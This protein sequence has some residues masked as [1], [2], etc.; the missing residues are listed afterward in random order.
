MTTTGSGWVFDWYEEGYKDLM[1][2]S[3]VS[4]IFQEARLLGR[5]KMAELARE[6]DA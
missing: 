3:E 2:D 1:S 5:P 4:A 6:H